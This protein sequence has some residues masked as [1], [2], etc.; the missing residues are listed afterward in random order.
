MVEVGEKEE[1]GGGRPEVYLPA[2]YG[3]PWR[4]VADDDN[5]ESCNDG[6]RNG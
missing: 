3:M 6:K 2:L 5:G 1:T 4:E